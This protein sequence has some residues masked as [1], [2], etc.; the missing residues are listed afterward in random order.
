MSTATISSGRYL[1]FAVIEAS[2]VNGSIAEGSGHWDMSARHHLILKNKKCTMVILDRRSRKI[3]KFMKPKELSFTN[4]RPPIIRY[5]Y[6]G[7]LSLC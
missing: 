1:P 4:P 5:G 6:L 7:P 3:Y 2:Q